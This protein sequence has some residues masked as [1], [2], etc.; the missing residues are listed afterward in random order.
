MDNL[1]NNNINNEITTEDAKRIMESRQPRQSKMVNVVVKDIQMDFGSMVIFMV[2]WAIAFIPAA[3]IL[4][5]IGVLFSGII[6]SAFK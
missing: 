6:I 4:F 3:I 2:K 1:K 5:I